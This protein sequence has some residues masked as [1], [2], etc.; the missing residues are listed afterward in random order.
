MSLLD[1]FRSRCPACGKR[2]LEGH[3]DK[4]LAEARKNNLRANPAWLWS[5]C[6]HCGA[7][8]KKEHSAEGTLSP[9]GEDEW[10]ERVSP[11]S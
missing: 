4:C 7:R 3:P 8:F 6:V 9:A 1:L 11:K 10:E 2:G 5:E